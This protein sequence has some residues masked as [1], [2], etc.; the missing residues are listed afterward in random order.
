MS[1]ASGGVIM[2][3]LRRLA[4]IFLLVFAVSGLPAQAQS[5]QSEALQVAN[6]LFALLSKDMLA[7]L[8]NSMTAQMWPMVERQMRPGLDAATLNELR[9]EFER[10]QK[11]SLAEAMQSAAPIYARHF[12]AGELRD[13]INFYNSP[14]GQKSLRE[15]PQVMSEIL[16]GTMPRMQQL[17]VQASESFAKILRDRGYL[18]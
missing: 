10:I 17:Q 16:T 18:K 1:R 15:L 4:I 13:L 6:E 12:T 9:S 11:A 7:D 2:W 5:E 3:F 8:T 14:T